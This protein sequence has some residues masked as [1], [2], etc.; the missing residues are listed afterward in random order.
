MKGALVSAIIEA[1]KLRF[2]VDVNVGRLARRLRMLGYDTLF[3][4]GADDDE[5]IRIALE[6]KRILLT[7][8]T[9]M[10]Q[11]RVVTI[12]KAQAV[13]VESD[14]VRAQLRQVVQALGL[15]PEFDS[16]SLCIECNEPLIPRVKEEVQTLI[17]PY[18]FSTQEQFMQCPECERIYWRGTHWDRM[19]A[20]IEDL[21]N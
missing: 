21:E 17:P 19:M 7:R 13:F 14:H 2:I 5:L 9:G 3:I 11:R 16:F 10:M 15:G 1:M 8:D 12:G 20:E 4:N 18:V 6:E